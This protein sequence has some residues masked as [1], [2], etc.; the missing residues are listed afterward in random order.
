M[1]SNIWFTS[2]T[3]FHH[4]AMIKHNL[5]PF[6]SV[7]EMNETLIENWNALVKPKDTV[8][9]LGDVMVSKGP[10]VLHRLNGYK[11]LVAGNHDKRNLNKPEFKKNFVWIKEYHELK[12]YEERQK[13]VLFHFPILV[14]NQVH[15][16]AWMLCGHSHG[17]CSQTR[18][19]AVY[20]RILDVGTDVHKFAP[21]EYTQIKDIMR[22]K[23]GCYYDHH[24]PRGE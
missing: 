3:H 22:N 2:D 5:R 14:W 7:E 6:T 4:A 1:T 13:I 20:G 11:Y 17:S 9:H 15:Y 8:Y 24:L 23:I 19:E 16:K 10:E 21:I 12:L 18:P